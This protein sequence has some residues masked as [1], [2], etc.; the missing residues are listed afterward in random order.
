LRHHAF[1]RVRALTLAAFGEIA[2]KE[3]DAQSSNTVGEACA[4]RAY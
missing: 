1:L 4:L 3:G 2:L